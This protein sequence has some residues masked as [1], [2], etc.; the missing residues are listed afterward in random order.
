MLYD[1]FCCSD[2]SHTRKRP[3]RRLRKTSE[4]LDG[5]SSRRSRRRSREVQIDGFQGLTGGLDDVIISPLETEAD[6][7]LDIKIKEDYLYS[8]EF[9]DDSGSM[10]ERDIINSKPERDQLLEGHIKRRKHAHE[11][12]NIDKT[13]DEGDYDDVNDGSDDLRGEEAQL[14]L[15]L[16]LQVGQSVDAYEADGIDDDEC[17][18]AGRREAVVQLRNKEEATIDE[19]AE[20]LLY[21]ICIYTYALKVIKSY[22]YR[23]RIKQK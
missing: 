15:Q 9:D 11:N 1:L 10:L 7:V 13:E 6:T 8:I 3:L 19:Q 22:I 18:D 16:K 17:D 2:D 20:Q 5:G 4:K 12:S 21:I 23:Y 14:R